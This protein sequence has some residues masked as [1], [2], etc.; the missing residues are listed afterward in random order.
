MSLSERWR[1]TRANFKP[2]DVEEAIDFHFHR[3]VAGL[4]V[5]MIADWPI[6]PNQVTVASGVVSALAGRRT[7]APRSPTISSASSWT[8]CI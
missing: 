8:I 5:Q 7:A 6:T 2:R 3:P 1:A 4:L